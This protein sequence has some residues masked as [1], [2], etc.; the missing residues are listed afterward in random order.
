[1]EYNEEEVEDVIQEEVEHEVDD[2][3][4]IGGEEQGRILEDI[5]ESNKKAGHA[6][7]RYGL[8]DLLAMVYEFNDAVLAE[9]K[10]GGKEQ[11][12]FQKAVGRVIQRHGEN[13]KGDCDAPPKEAVMDKTEPHEALIYEALIKAQTKEAFVENNNEDKALT[14]H[15]DVDLIELNEAS[16]QKADLENTEAGDPE[17]DLNAL[18]VDNANIEIRGDVDVNSRKDGVILTVEESLEKTESVKEY[19]MDIVPTVEDEELKEYFSS[20]LDAG[21]ESSLEKSSTEQSNNQE[22]PG[23]FWLTEGKKDCGDEG[24]P[25]PDQRRMS[26]IPYFKLFWEEVLL[27]T[28]LA[29]IDPYIPPYMRPGFI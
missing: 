25:H 13:I 18:K 9:E 2:A 11:T 14:K 19:E 16:I 28:I 24:I 1:L 22:Q 20:Q 5:Q 10:E 7:K 26:K 27:P 4:E 17:I 21:Q 6:E 3:L 15:F 23:F 29:K 8:K 12:L